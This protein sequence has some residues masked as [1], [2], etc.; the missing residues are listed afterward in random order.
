VNGGNGKRFASLIWA[1]SEWFM[2]Q[3]FA[4][5]GYHSARSSFWI[6]DFFN[7]QLEIDRAGDAAA[8]LLKH[9]C[10]EW[11]AMGLHHL[12]KSINSRVAGNVTT[13][14]EAK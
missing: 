6:F 14:I 12:V 10:L 1:S 11:G 8:E 7:V 5:H 2:R 9:Q 4:G 3:E 13:W